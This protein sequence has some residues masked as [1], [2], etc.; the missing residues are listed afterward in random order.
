MTVSNSFKTLL[1]RIQPLDSEVLA[2]NGHISTIKSRLSETFNV[3]KPVITGSFSR[4]SFIR[5]KSDVD[6]FVVVARDDVRWGGN[7]VS[8]TTMLDKIRADLK[9]RFW[10]TPI[11]KD[12]QAVVLD[13]TD[14]RV[15]VVPAYFAGTTTN[16]WPLYAMPDGQGSWMNTCPELHNAYINQADKKSGGQLKYTAQLMKFWRECRNPRIPISS[17]HIEMVLASE[18]ICKGVKSYAECIR[19][20]LQSIAT[21]QCRAMQDPLGISGYIPCTKTE[22]QR[23]VALESVRYSRDHAKYACTS[24]TLLIEHAK[25]QWD[26]VFNGKFPW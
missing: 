21:R 19:D 6:L 1:S 8:S 4:G 14:C 13:F 10:N 23:L 16:N 18:E 25:Q 2:A 7:Y 12:A 3:K 15:D 11:T 17:F 5:G 9:E 20:I 24:V 22:A 26:I